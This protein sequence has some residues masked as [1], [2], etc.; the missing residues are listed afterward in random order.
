MARGAAVPDIQ[1][2]RGDSEDTRL[3]KLRR[4]A[5][6]VQ[7]LSRTLGQSPASGGNGDSEFTMTG[8]GVLGRLA[9]TGAANTL[10]GTDVN[11]LLPNFSATL[12]GTVP[13]PGTLTNNR[14]LRDDGAWVTVSLSLGA[15]ANPTAL[16]GLTAVNGS[17]GTAMRS[18]AA[19][20]LDQGITPTWTGNHLWGDNVE[21][22]LGDDGDVSF[23]FDGT[24]AVLTS[25]GDFEI[26]GVSWT[27]VATRRVTRGATFTTGDSATALTTPVNDVMVRIPFACTIRKVTV[28]TGG[29]P[30][31]CELD[32]WSDTYGNFPP[33]V[34]DSIVAAAPPVIT[35][36]IKYE[37]STLTG[38]DTAVAAGD[39]LVFHLD[40]T[41]TF[42]TIFI[43]LELEPV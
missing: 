38:W 33:T 15:L 36:D 12:K 27:A 23:V 43:I 11:S 4:L 28:L 35:A 31:D 16:V 34:V 8:P 42:H 19:P 20:A 3:E 1:F 37:D 9:G 41:T 26:N 39:V 21:I 25:A 2:Q 14:F 22:L 40:S 18:D 29:G 10:S 17:A 13:S 5:Q 30:G 24:D 7:D 6:V 32:I